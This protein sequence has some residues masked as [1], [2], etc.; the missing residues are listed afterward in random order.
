MKAY[1][2]E[3]EM[4]EVREKAIVNSDSEGQDQDQTQAQD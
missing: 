4:E 1:G 3:D 2:V